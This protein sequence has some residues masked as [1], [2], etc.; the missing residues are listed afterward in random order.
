MEIVFSLGMNC[1]FFLTLGYKTFLT[2]DLSLPVTYI[3]YKVVSPVH[4]L[5]I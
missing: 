1:T 4:S 5:C 2:S 3:G